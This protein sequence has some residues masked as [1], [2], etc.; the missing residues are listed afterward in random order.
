M[1][2]ELGDYKI[3]ERIGV[4]GLGEIYRARD[5]RRGRTVALKVVPDAIARDAE[6]RPRLLADARAA[7]ALS[8]PNIAA[9]YEVG[10]DREHLFLACEFVPGDTLTSAI[11]GGPMN[12][13]HAAEHGV[14]IADALAEAHA[15]GIVH[16]DIKPDNIIITPKGS[17]KI[18]D[19]GLAAWTKGGAER[20]AA[21]AAAFTGHSVPAAAAYMSPEQLKGL[22]VD[23][24]T[25]IF[26]FGVVLFEMLTGRRPFAG[27]TLAALS[28][29]ILLSNPPLPS[30]LN[31][32]L[33][34]DFDAILGRALAKKPDDRYEAAATLAAELRSVA[35]ILDVRSGEA[36][37]VSTAPVRRGAPPNRKPL[38]VGA[39]ALAF[40]AAFVVAWLFLNR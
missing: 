1:L 16:G 25:D 36:E 15:I 8:H 14:Q 39:I 12:A 35:A 32:E 2:D 7:S 29:E 18:L 40:V 28:K 23:H 20:Q 22:P 19:F 21:A 6:R 27:L 4:G 17:A 11:A 10:E 34:P 30:A 24:R 26:S 13:R 5:T 33:R 37:P 3:L 9:L 31:W 38:I